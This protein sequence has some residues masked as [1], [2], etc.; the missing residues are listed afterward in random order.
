MLQDS[1]SQER[2]EI[3]E[4]HTRVAQ[5]QGRYESVTA[6]VPC[7]SVIPGGSYQDCLAKVSYQE[8]HANSALHKFYNSV[9][10]TVPVQQCPIRAVYSSVIPK[11]SLQECHLKSVSYKRGFLE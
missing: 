1:L 11:V 2:H 5:E 8:S 6:S 10:P 4:C 7:K 9:I 3:Q